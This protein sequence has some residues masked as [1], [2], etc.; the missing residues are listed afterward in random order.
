MT[1]FSNPRLA[2][3]PCELMRGCSFADNFVNLT[4]IADNFGTDT[5]TGN[6]AN[7]GLVTNGSGYIVYDIVSQP[8]NFSITFSF[9]AAAVSADG[10][11]ISSGDI[12]PGYIEDG[13]DIYVDATG[14]RANAGGGGNSSDP[15]T[16]DIAYADSVHHTVTYVVNK[17]A[18]THSLYVDALAVNTQD[19][20]DADAESGTTR[21]I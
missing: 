21:A 18:G 15:C 7:H 9:K 11:L 6:T 12:A 1:T 2:A 5:G 20:D 8:G 14:I 10:H 19:Y 13:F 3:L 17:T 4:R 16:V